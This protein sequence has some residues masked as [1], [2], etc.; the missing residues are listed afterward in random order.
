MAAVPG[1]LLDH[2]DH[3]VPEFERHAFSAGDVV[4]VGALDGVAGTVALRPVIRHD[5]GER[6]AP[7]GT[8]VAVRVVR[9]VGVKMPVLWGHRG[10][11][12]G[13]GMAGQKG[14]GHG[15]E[16]DGPDQH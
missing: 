9:L 4:E 16:G 13:R 2:V 12:A 14:H 10:R 6:V 3:G 11:T 5:A 8:E 15:H 1:G 7:P